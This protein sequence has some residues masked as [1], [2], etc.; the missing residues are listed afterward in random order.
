VFQY[1][2]PCS[3]WWCEIMSLNC[4]HRRACCLSPGDIW[5]RITTVKWYRQG[6]LLFRPP[7]L[8]GNSTSSHVVANQEEHDKG[9]AEFCLRSI[10]YILTEFFNMPWIQDMQPTA[11]L[12]L[13][14]KSCWWFLSPLKIQSFSA[15]FEPTNLG[16]Y[17]HHATTR[18]PRA[19]FNT[20]LR[21][22]LLRELN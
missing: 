8:S 16:P 5:V 10:S 14:R 15:W 22:V 7:E 13:Q 1:L 3:C 20:L 11:L 19:I 21:M 6:N 2:V 4:D 17:C 18:P 12:L 9:S